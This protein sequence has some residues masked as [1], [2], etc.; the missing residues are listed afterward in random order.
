SAAPFLLLQSLRKGPGVEEPAP[1]TRVRDCCPDQL[2]NWCR[3]AVSFS[4]KKKRKKRPAQRGCA[5]S[6]APP[7][8]FP[9]ERPLCAWLGFLGIKEKRQHDEHHHHPPALDV[10]TLQLV[11]PPAPSP[12]RYG[13]KSPFPPVGGSARGS[14]GARQHHHKWVGHSGRVVG[15]TECQ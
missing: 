2:T 9:D 5:P 8:P 12:A 11:S 15:I 7:R 6:R 14:L 4:D 10:P 1:A 3:G 13:A